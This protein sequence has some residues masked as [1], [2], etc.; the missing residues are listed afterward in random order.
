MKPLIARLTTMEPVRTAEEVSAWIDSR[1]L[2][3]YRLALAIVAR[4]DLAEDATQ[5]ALIRAHRSVEKLRRVDRPEAWLRTVVVRCA[6]RCRLDASVEI[7]EEAES[8]QAD[9]A[10]GIAVRAALARL[11]PDHQAIL[12]LA[13]FEQLSYE[14][15]AETLGVP[16]GTVASRVNAA[17]KAF[18]RVWEEE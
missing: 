18:R 15:I 2:P 6:M 7:P 9:Q 3:A 11:S 8:Q 17:K 14:E 1:R 5:E 13:M 12:A 10:T 4:T 16:C